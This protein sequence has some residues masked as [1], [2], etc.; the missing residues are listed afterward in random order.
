MVQQNFPDYP[1]IRLAD[2]PDIDV[3]H[4]REQRHHIGGAGEVGVPAV[5]PALVQ[6]DLF[7]AT[8]VCASAVASRS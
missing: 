4:H 6:C 2:C 8:G 1:V 5:A 7:A 3:H